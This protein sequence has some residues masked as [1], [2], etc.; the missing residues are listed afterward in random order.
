MARWRNRERFRWTVF[1]LGGRGPLAEPLEADG[2]RI[3]T[4]DTPG[5]FRFGLY[6]RLAKIFRAE[7]CD[8]VHSHDDRP[9]VYAMAAA[10]WAGVKRRIHTH[11]HGRLASVSR[12]QSFL[13]RQAS[14][15]AQHFV[16][17]SDDS[18]RFMAEQGVNPKV[19]KTIRNGIDLTRF[20]FQGPCADGSVVTVARL[21]P[22][23]DVANLLRAAE[24]VVARFPQV[25]FEI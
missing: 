8:V 2:V 1:V 25:R 23:K 17:V 12:R 21:S 22:E 7:Q 18:A 13:I 15:F 4:L 14:R 11:H 5:G 20:S 3:V 24:R 9:L 19:I 6:R 16:C 10:W